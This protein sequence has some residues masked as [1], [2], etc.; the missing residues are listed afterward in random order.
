ML[1]RQY[2]LRLLAQNHSSFTSIQPYYFM[3]TP[4]FYDKPLHM[5]EYFSIGKI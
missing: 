5:H 4:L 2:F 3:K 1:G